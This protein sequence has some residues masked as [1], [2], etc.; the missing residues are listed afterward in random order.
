LP[1]KPADGLAGGIDWARDD[2][3]VAIVDC[4]GFEVH[5]CAVE[6]SAAGLG[7]LVA[8]PVRFGVSEVAI[9]RPDGPVVDALLAAGIAVVV[10]ST[11]Q[12]KNCAATTGRPATKTTASTPSFWLIRCATTASD[13][14]RWSP[15]AQPRWRC[16]QHAGPRKDLVIHRVAM[17][18]Q[19]REH[20]TRVFPGVLGL[21]DDLDSAI[22]LKF[23]TR[24]DSQ[25][26]ADWLTPTRG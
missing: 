19:L 12:L 10:I 9:E 11:N 18:N 14:A 6:H 20:L 8:V 13:C 7:E 16:A 4:R 1:V 3:A 5:R 26:R 24:F 17:T 21:F 22:S 15:T 25:D 2:H 23:L